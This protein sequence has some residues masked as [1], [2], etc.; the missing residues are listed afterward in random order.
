M[1]FLQKGVWDIWRRLGRLS[2]RTEACFS[3][4]DE[5]LVAV[6]TV[7]SSPPSDGPR[8]RNLRFVLPTEVSYKVSMV[9]QYS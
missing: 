4:C 2:Y 1:H 7:Y 9:L 6:A 3:V 8:T 5:A